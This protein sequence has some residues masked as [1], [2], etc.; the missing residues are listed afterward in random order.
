MTSYNY[1]NGYS[2]LSYMEYPIILVQ[3]YILIFLVLKYLNKI[4][5]WSLVYTIIYFVIG[6]CLLF[7]ILPKIVLTFL[8]VSINTLISTNPF[9]KK[10]LKNVFTVQFLFSK[11]HFDF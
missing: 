3:E 11:T 10:A 8:A 6:S 9:C 1:T 5:K 2:V 7:E 4:N